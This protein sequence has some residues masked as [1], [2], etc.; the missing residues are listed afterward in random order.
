[1]AKTS[2]TISKHMG[3]QIL[4]ISILIPGA[5]FLVVACQWG[6]AGKVPVT[7]KAGSTVEPGGSAPEVSRVSHDSKPAGSVRFTAAD[8]ARHVD[9]LGARIN[10]LLPPSAV[11]GGRGSFPATEFSIVIEA[12]FVVIGDEP[13]QAVQ[14]H[15]EGTV[16][17]AV[18]RLKRDF[19][20]NDPNDILDIWLF[21]DAASY[22]KHTRIFFGE[23]PTTPYGYYSS[24]HKA[25]IMNIETG[26]G[27]LVHE[28]V[29]P[30]MEANFPA[31]PPWLNEGLGSLYEQCGDVKG[32]IH[33]FT[34]WRLP[35]LQ[36]AIKLAQVPS[37]KTLT[38][39]D[40]SAFYNED[41]GT[42][43]AQARYLC[44]YMQEKGVLVKFYQE[45]CDHQN[46][47]PSGFNTLQKV[48]AEADMNTFKTKWE[49]YVLT[50]RQGYGVT[51]DTVP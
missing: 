44:Y 16:K 8:F 36:R 48:L 34:N 17:W 10:K 28:I 26:G 24:D 3:T 32:H 18:E 41:R 7:A 29:H 15:A 39:M 21:K 49:K 19:F 11:P 40:P 22:E 35:G 51:V 5:L 38:A 20:V 2:Q 6:G 33:G 1:M 45:F 43:Y 27:T 46:E 4:R 23:T 9:Q 47:D 14:Q 30:F 31:C 42:N 50:L 13:K 12:P 25:L 37:F